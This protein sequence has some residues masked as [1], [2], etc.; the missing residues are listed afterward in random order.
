MP[1]KESK[2]S[3]SQKE[4]NVRAKE[5]DLF[6]EVKNKETSKTE[7]SLASDNLPSDSIKNNELEITILKSVTIPNLEEKNHDDIESLRL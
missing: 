5:L 2:K 3:L 4:K 1:C 7:K 6:S